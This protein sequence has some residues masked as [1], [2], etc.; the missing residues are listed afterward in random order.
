MAYA[1]D[2]PWGA[3]GQDSWAPAPFVEEAD[4][5]EEAEEQAAQSPARAL[6]A[7]VIRGIGA[8]ISVALV[9]GVAV[10]GYRL[11]VRDATGVPVVQAME[12]PL[13]EA[14]SEP[15]GEIASHIGLSVNDVAAM[16][17]AAG[18][19]ERLILAPQPA[20][21]R[22]ED[23]LLA[24]VAEADE[25]RPEG[26]SITRALTAMSQGAPLAVAQV[27]D[28]GAVQALADRLAA[29]VVPIEALSDEVDTEVLMAPD[30]APEGEVAADAGADDAALEDDQAEALDLVA[31]SVPG[32]AVAPRPPL[33]PRTLRP[34]T[35]VAALTAPA[36][37]PASTGPVALQTEPIPAGTSL[38]Q[39][40]AFDSPEVAAAEWTRLGTRFAELLN[41]K[42]RVVQE[43][44]SGG[45]TFFRLRAM[46]FED[47]ADAR[48][49]CSALVA[50][51]AACIPVVVN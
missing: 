6:P 11:M 3:Q 10:W 34:A 47:L 23:L 1:A 39:L 22:Q 33:R 43:A 14:P 13:R 26:D 29:G 25:S 50:E 35:A 28:P 16:G 46:G 37:A 36:A 42:E 45:R 20:G 21:L 48:R 18:P 9:I 51:D 17:E 15:G 27:G 2:A 41:G 31:A 24:P 49:F 5:D 30:A 12:G 32:L 38:V 8:L 44:L 19:E 40:G 7:K 4:W